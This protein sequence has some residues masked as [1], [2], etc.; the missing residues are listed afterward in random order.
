MR[1]ITLISVK[2]VM[3]T[4]PKNLITLVK[5][6]AIQSHF[7]DLIRLFIYKQIQFGFG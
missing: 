6:S 7:K 5:K 4:N 2:S 1:I 3:Q